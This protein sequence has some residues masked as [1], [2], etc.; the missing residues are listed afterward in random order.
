MH[1]KRTFLGL[2]TAQGLGSRILTKVMLVFSKP[3]NFCSNLKDYGPIIR[4][5]RADQ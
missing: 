1:A 2:L 4:K 3:L 5:N